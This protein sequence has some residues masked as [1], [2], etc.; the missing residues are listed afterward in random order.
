M[1]HAI[2]RPAVGS[3][4][5]DRFF[6]SVSNILLI[7]TLVF[8]R[9]VSIAIAYFSRLH[10]NDFIPCYVSLYFVASYNKTSYIAVAKAQVPF[11]WGDTDIRQGE[12]F[13]ITVCVGLLLDTWKY[14]LCMRRECLERFPNPHGLAI[15]T[16][17]TPL[18]W[19]TCHDACRCSSPDLPPSHSY[20]LQP[21]LTSRG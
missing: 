2:F 21:I 17:I 3:L 14:G 16:C 6:T 5:G 15:P 1:S 4:F 8:D 19:C 18:V 11:K 13:K 9:C 12:E 20:P 10:D 7:S